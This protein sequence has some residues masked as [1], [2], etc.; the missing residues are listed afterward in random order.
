MSDALAQLDS[1]DEPDE[2]EMADSPLDD[3]QETIEFDSIAGSS[4]TIAGM[5]NPGD[6]CGAVR[7][8][9]F[10]DSCAEPRPVQMKCGKRVCPDC[11]VKWRADRGEA[12]AKRFC[13]ARYAEN[14]GID[15]RAVHATVSAPQ[16]AVTTLEDWYDG[17]RHA[18]QLAQQHGIRGGVCIGHGYRIKDEY[19]KEYRREYDDDSE[20]GMWQW[21]REELPAD[22]RFYTYWSPHWHIIGLSADFQENDPDAD[23][24][25]VVQRLR[26]LEAYTSVTDRDATE[27]TIGT[28]M[29]LLS[30][31]P[32]EPDSSRDCV[33]WFGDCSTASFS[34]EEELSDGS[35]RAI[36]RL[37]EELM[38]RD[39]DEE[40]PECDNCGST[41]FS[42]IFDAGAALLDRGWTERIGREQERRLRTAYEWAIGEVVPPPGLQNPRTEDEAMEAFEALL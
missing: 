18:Y 10:C 39:D 4:L 3:D 5:G 28:A 38:E 7:L 26:T 19:K 12:I 35:R 16:D 9:Q 30:H 42:S 17:Y 22:W 8:L 23:D 25:W 20:I 14:D 40:P 1:D 6:D 29:Y 33:R 36:D 13:K 34:A 27:E 11:W 32:F 37:V 41:T 31:A 21:V 15:R 24:G 2:P